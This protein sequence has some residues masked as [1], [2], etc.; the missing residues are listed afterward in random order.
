MIRIGIFENIK[1]MP[2][3]VRMLQHHPDVEIKW[4][5]NFRRTY[6]VA[7]VS[8]HPELAG[9][10]DLRYTDNCD[11]GEVDLVI[12][13]P[14][15]G[16][17]A[18]CLKDNPALKAIWTDEPHGR[19]GVVCGVPEFNRKALVRGAREAYMPSV[20]TLLCTLALMPQAK[21][22]LL[23]ES[24]GGALLLPDDRQAAWG[25]SWAATGTGAND[26][27][28]ILRQL[29]LSF[30]GKI[31]PLCFSTRGTVAMGTFTMP[32]KMQIDQLRQI[33]HDFYDDHRH[34]VILGE[35]Q[36]LSD[37]V[38]AGTNKAAIQL[39]EQ[40][41]TLSVSVGF[42]TAFR[43]GAGMTVHL[44]NLLFGLDERTGF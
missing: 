5:W 13:E 23:P 17:M 1:D 22:L 37:C 32:A 14:G 33:Y 29:Q 26:A 39:K 30:N 42:D 18:D 31:R 9:E 11:A 35:E 44:L 25:N 10:C 4:M 8:A 19:E 20:Y 28:D 36:F 12:G 7:S 21:N 6:P 24:I 34:V 41:G 2:R 3:L 38:I 27:M 43:N 15:N 40:D 16:D